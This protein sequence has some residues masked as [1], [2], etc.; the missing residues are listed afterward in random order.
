MSCFRRSRSQCVCVC[1][2]VSVRL[3]PQSWAVRRAVNRIEET[4]SKLQPS[5]RESYAKTC[6]PTR[7]RIFHFR[8][9]HKQVSSFLISLI[10][11]ARLVLVHEESRKYLSSSSSWTRSHANT[12]KK[13]MCWLRGHLVKEAP[14]PLC[15]HIFGCW[16]PPPHTD[17][18]TP[19][20]HNRD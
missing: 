17:T 6:T 7:Q 13:C 14:S 18:P 4:T 5:I 3:I 11:N 8:K 2:C 1:V 12:R 16:W 10:S 15:A 20:Q 9:H 19:H